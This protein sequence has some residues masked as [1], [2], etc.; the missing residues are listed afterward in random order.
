MLF[1]VISLAKG[2]AEGLWGLGRALHPKEAQ[3]GVGVREG[4]IGQGSD[5]VMR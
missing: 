5:K 4:I 3:K 2:E 1:G